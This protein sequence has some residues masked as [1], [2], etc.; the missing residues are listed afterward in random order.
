MHSGDES[1]P[2]QRFYSPWLSHKG[3]QSR[4][5]S[6]G[7]WELRGQGQ[8]QQAVGENIPTR[9]KGWKNNY[10]GQI[11]TFSSGSPAL[12]DWI[13]AW[14][15][16]FFLMPCSNTILTK[17]FM[18][19]DVPLKKPNALSKS[20]FRGAHPCVLQETQK[21]SLL[22]SSTEVLHCPRFQLAHHLSMSNRLPPLFV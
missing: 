21:F 3:E 11:E 6:P 9:H 7:S 4:E 1:L 10:Q 16:L 13:S 20:V 5:L 14:L 17:I 22:K 18:S 12:W 19:S 2:Q 8:R 15:F